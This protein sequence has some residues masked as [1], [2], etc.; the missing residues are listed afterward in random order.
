MKKKAPNKNRN[1]N[2]RITYPQTN[3]FATLAFVHNSNKNKK[4]K[5]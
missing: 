2:N 1:E 5:N 3:I 4:K